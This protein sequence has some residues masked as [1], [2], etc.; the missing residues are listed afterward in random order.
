MKKNKDGWKTV[1]G[2]SVYVEGGRVIRG[3][4]GACGGFEYRTA[5]PYRWDQRLGCWTAAGGLSLAA[6]RAGVARG[7]VDLK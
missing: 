4:L 1:Y 5:Y 6:F 2:L 3:T 7:T